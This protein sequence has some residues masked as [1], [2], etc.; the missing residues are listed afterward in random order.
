LTSAQKRLYFLQQ[1]DLNST[2]YNIPMVLPLGQGI[3]K[4][5]LGSTLKRLIARHESLRTSFDRVNEDIVQKIHPVDSIEFSLDYYKAE[6]IEIEGI[7]R[8]YIRPFDLSLTP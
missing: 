2:S 5:S 7:I 8:S 4:D 3:K 1:L 6:K